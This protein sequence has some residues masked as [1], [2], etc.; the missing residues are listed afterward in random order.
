[1]TAFANSRWKGGAAK[2][3]QQARQG[4]KALRKEQRVGG[5]VAALE[6]GRCGQARRRSERAVRRE[7][8]SSRL[9]EAQREQN[10]PAYV[11]RRGGGALRQAGQ[12]EKQGDDALKRQSGV[13]GCG[14]VVHA[15]AFRQGHDPTGFGGG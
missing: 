15:I 14:C 11:P 1:M 9:G 5:A 7:A 2:L 8:G 4:A 6:K 12:G 10:G 3:V 13:C